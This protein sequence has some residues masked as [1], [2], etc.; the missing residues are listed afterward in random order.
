M[1]IRT[2]HVSRGLVV[3]NDLPWHSR[4]IH[5]TCWLQKNSVSDVERI[6]TE[7]IKVT[8]KHYHQFHSCRFI[9]N[10]SK[11][12]LIPTTSSEQARCMHTGRHLHLAEGVREAGIVRSARK[13][14]LWKRKSHGVISFTTIVFH[15]P[16]YLLPNGNNYYYHL[17]GFQLFGVADISV[18]SLLF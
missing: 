10:H 6:K 14:G 9:H 2:L 11:P 4:T 7:N 8:K 5:E 12:L 17:F 3:A 1:L 18:V 13:T 15:K 16:K